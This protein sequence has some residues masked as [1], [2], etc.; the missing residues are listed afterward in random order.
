MGKSV[1]KSMVKTRYACILLLTC[2]H[3]LSRLCALPK[4]WPFDRWAC[5]AAFC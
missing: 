2:L 3:L 1:R 5:L 4:A